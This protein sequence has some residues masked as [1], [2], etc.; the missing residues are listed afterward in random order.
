MRIEAM[1]RQLDNL[2]QLAANMPPDEPQARL[3]E[4]LC[5]RTSGLMEQVVKHLLKE[6]AKST[7]AA[8][9][10]K[11]VEGKTD[12]IANLPNDK[13]VELLLSFSESWRDEYVANIS[14]EAAGALNSIVG[15]R[16]KLA[17]GIDP[18]GISYRRIFEYYTNVRTLFPVLKQIISKDK[19]RLR[20]TR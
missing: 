16:N 18:G 11:Y 1:E 8:E 7:S 6:Y 20:R 4:Y 15:L 5:I 17:H 14:E 13:L 3:A 12:R 10:A 19:R 9:V 2:F